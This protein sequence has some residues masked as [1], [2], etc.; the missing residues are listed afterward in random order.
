MGIFV[1]DFLWWGVLYGS[2]CIWQWYGT[3]LL[4]A[5]I[6]ALNNAI[7]VCFSIHQSALFRGDG[8]SQLPAGP[9]AARGHRPPSRRAKAIVSCFSKKNDELRAKSEVICSRWE[10]QGAKRRNDG[11]P[12]R[13]LAKT[14]T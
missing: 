9:L 4:G 7:D 10:E 2:P 6:P 3:S 11:R 12:K 13:F 1:W 8:D 5:G 14:L